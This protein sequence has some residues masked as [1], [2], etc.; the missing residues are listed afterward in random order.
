MAGKGRF[1][2]EEI[3]FV[4]R[5]HAGTARTDRPRYAE[6]AIFGVLVS[7]DLVAWAFVALQGLRA[8]VGEA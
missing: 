6:A 1:T 3:D 8:L 2:Q 5:L 4:A 7:A